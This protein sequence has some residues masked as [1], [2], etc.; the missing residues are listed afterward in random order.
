MLHDFW[1]ELRKACSFHQVFLEYSLLGDFLSESSCLVARSSNHMYQNEDV[2]W[3]KKP[4][5]DF[6]LQPN[7]SLLVFKSSPRR[8][9]TLWRRDKPSLLYPIH[10]ISQIKWLLFYTTNFEVVY[11]TTTIIIMD[12][13]PGTGCCHKKSL[14]REG[15]A[16]GS[17]GR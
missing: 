3:M 5:D 7:D 14:K 6:S 15:L 16:L 2:K 10:I 17:G 9:Q 11:D 1:G 4:L 8:T 12:F 13:L